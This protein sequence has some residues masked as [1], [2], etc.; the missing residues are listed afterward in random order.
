MAADL[1]LEVLAPEKLD[2]SVGE[3]AP[4]IACGV[5]ALPCL[6]MNDEALSGERLVVPVA[7]GEPDAADVE[8]PWDPDGQSVRLAESTWKV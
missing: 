5:E 1:Y 8:L 2:V 7:A 3:V 4:Q 6:G